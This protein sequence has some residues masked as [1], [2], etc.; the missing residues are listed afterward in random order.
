M[1]EYT[2]TY[3]NE[4]IDK[5][6]DGTISDK[7]RYQLEKQALD[8]PFLFDALEGYSLFDNV[9]EESEKI[10]TPT[11]IFTL[12]RI[13]VAASIVFLVAVM[14]NL[15]SNKSTP[16]ESDNTIAMVMDEEETKPEILV[17][18]EDLNTTTTTTSNETVD[19]KTNPTQTADD[20]NSNTKEV[21][22]K[23]SEKSKVTKE[24]SS[25]PIAVES[26]IEKV[27]NEGAQVVE[28]EEM[29]IEE[30]SEGIAQNESVDGAIAA[31]D[32]AK[33][34]VADLENSSALES[35]DLNQ[36]SEAVSISA[37]SKILNEPENKKRKAQAFTYY[38]AVP[39]IGKKIFDEYAKER[40]DERGLRQEKPQK[41]TIEFTIDK[42]GNLS[43]FHH[44]FSGCPECGPFAIS[45]LQNSGEWKT[46]PPGFSGKARYTFIF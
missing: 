1:A 19:P 31:Q 5:Y 26:R 30:D 20:P 2:Q 37:A 33:E 14:F 16:S 22:K 25:P 18:K 15:N 46:I 38:E 35:D 36:E 3:W 44:I 13:A 39:V 45:I 9:D 21:E 34:V 27:E 8:D 6:R 24:N 23:K 4:L 7:E 32:D 11:K 41:V 17:E 28:N 29:I 42:N 43:N 40:I 12:P 10:K